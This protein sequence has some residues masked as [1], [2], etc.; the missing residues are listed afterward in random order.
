M[1]TIKEV[2]AKCKSGELQEA[3]DIA[4]AD[5]ESDSQ[6][7][8]EQ[9]K[10]AWVLYYRIKEAVANDDFVILAS[11]L[12]ELRSLELI[13][14]TA[15]EMI[16]TN[17]LFKVAEYV[18]KQQHDR[19]DEAYSRLSAIYSLL[20]GYDF[21]PS[22]AYSA[23]LRSYIGFGNWGQLLEF[24]EWWDMDKLT[25]EDYEPFV[26]EQGRRLMS[27]AERA[28]IAKSKLLVREKDRVRIE[29]FLPKLDALMQSHSE[30]VYPGYYYG[31]LLIATGASRD[32]AL[33]VLVPFARK[34][35]TEFWVWQL[36]S[37]VYADEPEAQMACLL[38]AV[39]CK[40]RDS[41]LVKVRTKLAELY[42]KQEKYGHARYQI[43]RVCECY[44]SEGWMLPNEIGE[45]VRQSWIDTVKPIAEDLI[46]YKS[47]TDEMLCYDK[48]ECW[49]VVTYVDAKSK[50]AFMVYG[51][52]RTMS[53]R[54]TIKVSAG[55]VL[56]IGY[57]TERGDSIKV[58]DVKRDELPEGLSYAKVVEG[59]VSR[60]EGNAFA[61]LKLR[62]VN[63]YIGAELVQRADLQNG[64]TI[65]GL[66]VYDYNKK[67]SQWN[68]VCVDVCK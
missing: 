29:Q 15:D 47:V 50:K 21:A 44:M 54:L 3:Y 27:L 67:K 46:E 63:C 7:E 9:R 45:W 43:D 32:E 2:I 25:R 49:A 42:I 52:K 48:K 14:V 13:S 53:Q 38:R 59:V 4:K 58:V 24:F 10:M 61:F 1:G 18:R 11:S 28:Y 31:K 26:T 30:M 62:T 68:W 20:G 34:K 35:S 12:D 55:E 37:E 57:V 56:K 16:F 40:T 65:R 60:R 6:N 8:W 19:D 33:R 23:L 36:L 17:V 5:W 51:P 22:K 64:A 39:H 66:V 41:F